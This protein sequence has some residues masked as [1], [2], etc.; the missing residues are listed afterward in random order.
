M[1]KTIRWK[2]VLFYTKE[3]CER[4]NERC[5]RLRRIFFPTRRYVNANGCKFSCV[6]SILSVAFVLCTHE[7]RLNWVKPKKV[8][9]KIKFYWNKKLI[10]KFISVILFIQLKWQNQ[11]SIF[12]VRILGD[13]NEIKIVIAC[14]HRSAKSGY[15][16][17]EAEYW[18]FSNCV[19]RSISSAE[20]CVKVLSSRP[21]KSWT[22]VF[23]ITIDWKN[24]STK[25][26][27]SKN[28]F[29]LK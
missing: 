20:Y 29:Q 22:Q 12:C 21:Q 9:L 19:K 10:L 27:R 25:I 7:F 5:S 13:V 23:Y 24:V 11:N 14:H 16:K 3:L 8:P 26:I 28:R 17:S 15:K 4:A 6:S 1:N 2:N 18:F